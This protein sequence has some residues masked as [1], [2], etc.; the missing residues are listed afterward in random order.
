MTD[1]TA[2]LGKI[3]PE[4]SLKLLRLLQEHPDLSQ[5]E[6]ARALGLSLGKTHYCVRALLDKGL[7]KMHDFTHSNNKRGYAYLLTPA[8]LC[9]KAELTRAFLH[10]KQ[11]EYETLKYEIAALRREV[12][13]QQA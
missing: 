3:H 4:H 6:L 5:R 9:A 7:I 11:A 12:D 8:G 2:T 13:G 10:Q 1:P